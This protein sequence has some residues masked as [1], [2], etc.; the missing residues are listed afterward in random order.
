MGLVTGT[1]NWA[2]VHAGQ[3][4]R[5]YA[6]DKTG[7]IWSIDLVVDSANES[8]LKKEGLAHLI[9]EKDGVRYIKF[10][11]NEFSKQT[12][13]PNTP[14]NVVDSQKNPMTAEIGNGS[15]V[16]ISFTTYT[17][18]KSQQYATLQTV[19]VVKLV[20]YKGKKKGDDPLWSLDK[21]EGGFVANDQEATDLPFDEASE[22]V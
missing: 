21:V 18:Y 17:G 2:K 3:L 12:G 4:D 6:K 5:T 10:K 19:Q 20:P 22:A 9:Q 11:R 16:N 13:K 1:V 7:G 15:M 8:M 14:P